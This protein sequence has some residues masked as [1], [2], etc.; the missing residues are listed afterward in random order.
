MMPPVS[1]E[2]VPATAEGG[3]PA[4]AY[5]VLVD[6]IKTSRCILFLGAGVHH[7]PPAGSRFSYPIEARPPLGSA[8]ALSLVKDCDFATVCRGTSLR[9]CSA[10]P[11][12]TSRRSGE[13]SS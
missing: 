13:T 4:G 10:F 6:S 12:A 11:S 7:E 2:L 9:I 8:L 1:A 3:D 5:R